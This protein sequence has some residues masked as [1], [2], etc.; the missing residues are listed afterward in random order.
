MSTVSEH[1]EKYKSVCI[2][3]FLNETETVY[4]HLGNSH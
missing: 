4:R 2:P 1:S 3:K